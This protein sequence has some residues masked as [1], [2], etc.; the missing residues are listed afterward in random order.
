MDQRQACELTGQPIEA[1]LSAIVGGGVQDRSVDDNNR[2]VNHA[3]GKSIGRQ[4]Q[5][6]DII[7]YFK[8]K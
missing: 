8:E 5:S 1:I 4:V 7:A 6:D 3:T 2:G